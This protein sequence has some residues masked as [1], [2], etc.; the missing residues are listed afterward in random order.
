MTPETVRAVRRSLLSWYA[1]HG[2]RAL[3]WRTQRS[4]YRTVVSEFMLQQTQVERVV[5]LFDAFVAR[6]PDFAALAAAP[7]ADV[8]RAWRGL[9]YNARAIRLRGVAEVVVARFAG[10]MPRDRETLLSLSGIGAYTAAA[11]RAF[12]FDMDDVPADT[13]V[14]RILHR[15]YR[16]IEW[17]RSAADRELDGL[18]RELMPKGK[19]HDWYSSLMDL[20]AAICTARAPQCIRCPLQRNCVAAPIDAS[21]LEAARSAARAGV[22]SGQRFE[23]TSRY[24]RGRIVDRLRELPP[25]RRISLLDLHRCLEP[26]LPGRSARDVYVL[27]AALERDGLVNSDGDTVSLP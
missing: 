16:G 14:R 9:G 12:A 19:A 2:R 8:V 21:K 11:L 26:M 27:V 24:A 22:R 23:A 10:A 7:A 3:P 5:P 4:P 1:R 20:G 13:N 25:G 6:F 15:L 17:P 18:A